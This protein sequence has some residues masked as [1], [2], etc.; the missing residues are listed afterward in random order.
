M[1]GFKTPTEE[2]IK[3]INI[4]QRDFFSELIDVFDP[5]LPEGVPDRLKTIVQMADITRGDVVLDVGTGT[6]ILIPLIREHEPSRIIACDLSEEMLV[7]LRKNHPYVE[8]IVS[9]IRD[10]SLP[11]GS[12]DV[13]FINACY[14]N[15]AHKPGSFENISRMM[16]PRGRAV[17]SHP[18]GKSFID[19]L[20]ENSP[21]PLDDFPERSEAEALFQPYQFD[22]QAFV[23][24]PDLYVLVMTKRD[25]SS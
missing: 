6:G 18:M 11:D 15:I 9:D 13:V 21:F 7:H 12:V 2:E 5:P 19:S 3:K 4:R 16:R 17:I 14:P 20:K 24:E 8:T 23:D 22:V 10:L 25:H 1:N